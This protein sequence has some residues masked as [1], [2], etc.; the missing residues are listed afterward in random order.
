MINQ[1]VDVYG[2]F[3]YSTGPWSI[4]GSV[5]KGGEIY[6]VSVSY[7]GKL[8]LN[9]VELGLTVNLQNV[10]PYVAEQFTRAVVTNSGLSGQAIRE[11]MSRQDKLNKML[12]GQ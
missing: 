9:S 4:S 12:D 8:R 2:K 7:G 10:A 11:L 5:G 1:N 3:S 6:D